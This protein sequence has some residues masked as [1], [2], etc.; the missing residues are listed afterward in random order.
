MWDLV[1]KCG[2]TVFGTSA[3]WID[4]QVIVTSNLS[5]NKDN[6]TLNTYCTFF[7]SDQATVKSDQIYDVLVARSREA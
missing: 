2:I 7:I 6:L 1:D 3:K 4:V 5:F